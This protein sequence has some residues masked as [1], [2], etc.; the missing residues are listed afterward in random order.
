MNPGAMAEQAI[1]QEGAPQEERKA[2]PSA[3]AA[4]AAT[5]PGA[6]PEPEPWAKKRWAQLSNQHKTILALAIALW[7][8]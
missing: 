3:A 4:L 5:K 8:F 6:G 1:V 2:L 7:D